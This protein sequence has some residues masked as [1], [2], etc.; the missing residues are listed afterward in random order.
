MRREDQRFIRRSDIERRHAVDH[1]G[2]DFRTDMEAHSLEYSIGPNQTWYHHTEFPFRTACLAVRVFLLPL[3]A[4]TK[5]MAGADEVGCLDGGVLVVR[6][7]R[8]P[9]C[10]LVLDIALSAIDAFLQWLT[11]ACALGQADIDKA[12]PDDPVVGHCIVQYVRIGADRAASL[13][14]TEEDRVTNL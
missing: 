8:N 4:A 12:N 3:L 7:G 6:L 1:V 14:L 9:R 13:G 5:P 11:R 10:Q 2:D